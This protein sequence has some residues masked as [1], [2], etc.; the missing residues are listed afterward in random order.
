MR[1]DCKRAATMCVGPTVL[2]ASLCV[3]CG[4]PSGTALHDMGAADHEAAATA[5]EAR[6]EQANTAAR[7]QGAVPVD[8][9][10]TP[11]DDTVCWSSTAFPT[12]N[13]EREAE[14]HRGLAIQHRA[15]SVA[16]LEAEARACVGI[17]P[18]DRDLSPFA[19]TEDIR[20]V[21]PLYET[22][23]VQ[24]KTPTKHLV[25]AQV[26]FR[27]VT[28]MTAEWLQ[29]LLDCHGARNAAIGYATT[30][31]AM[32]HCPLAIGPVTTEASSTGD[33]FTV[34]IRA[35]ENQDAEQIR[36]RAM[37]LRPLHG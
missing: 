13:F 3:A 19:H 18:T 14:R 34:E 5:E 1:R 36:D 10:C 37:G 27:A 9:R 11:S 35:E 20:A 32:P 29:R 24:G 21:A 15:A 26:V 4:P 2:A 22:R 8:P 23:M 30:R 31:T 7:E 12:E 16:L 28:G 25:G 17:A 33:G 6:A